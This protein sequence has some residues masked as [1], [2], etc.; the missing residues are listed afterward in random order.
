VERDRKAAARRT[1]VALV[2][3]TVTKPNAQAQDAAG[4]AEAEFESVFLQNYNRI[5]GVLFRLVG[6]RAEAED[7]A[8]ET[9]WKY[10]QRPP[11][12]ADNLIGWLYRVATNLGYNALR[13]AKRRGK[14]EEEAG[15]DALDLALPREPAQEAERRADRRKVRKVLEQLNARDAQ[16]LVLR[17][18]GFAYK[19]IAQTLGV[20]P[21]SVGTLLARA[22][23]EFE[24]LYHETSD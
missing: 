4:Q 10:W 5:Y 12:R 3:K 16:I 14:Y 23:K 1:P 7:L 22:E 21:T 13:A 15:R 11:S 6:D 17:H 8:L 24:R 20:A 2:S 19:E 18:S 9:F